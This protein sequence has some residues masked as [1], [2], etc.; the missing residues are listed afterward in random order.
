V[1]S[2]EEPVGN[3]SYNFFSETN[4]KTGVPEVAVHN[5]V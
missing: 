4:V 3:A 2:E 1:I 5:F